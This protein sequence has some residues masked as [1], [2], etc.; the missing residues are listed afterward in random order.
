MKWI[1]LCLIVVSTAFGDFSQMLSLTKNPP[2]KTTSPAPEAVSPE[3][4]LDANLFRPNDQVSE[5]HVEFLYWK[6]FT[7]D[8]IFAQVMTEP[9]W[10]DIGSIQVGAMGNY[11]TS[12]FNIDPGFRIS[13]SFFRASRFWEVW[14]SYTRLTARGKNNTSASSS[15]NNFLVSAW[16]L[17]LMNALKHAK[18]T[19][20]FNYNVS[21]FYVDRYFNPNPHLRIRMLAGLTG[22]WLTLNWT[23]KFFDITNQTARIRSTWDYWG[24]GIRFGM[25]GDWYW[26]ND[27]Y[28]TIRGTLAGLVG[29]YHNRILQT[30][31]VSSP[32]VNN[33]RP[34]RKTSYRDTRPVGNLQLLIGPSWQKNWAS[35]R[36]EL[37]DKLTR[38]VPL[39]SGSAEYTY[40]NLDQ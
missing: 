23:M 32:G 19:L 18:S 30:E 13:Q 38:S 2:P 25:T 12:Q 39:N 37:F 40:R 10:A 24:C 27:I 8:L 36:T 22:T 5:T 31:N 11:K 4:A 20:H 15:A 28:L 1:F 16:P 26:S 21:D 14:G 35:T 29:P 6:T 7:T 33:T 3:E 9:S 17:P 34:F